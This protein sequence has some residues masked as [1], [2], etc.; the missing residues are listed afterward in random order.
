MWSKI[1]VWSYHVVF[2]VYV[3]YLHITI[4]IMV[5]EAYDKYDVV[6]EYPYLFYLSIFNR[7]NSVKL[8]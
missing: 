2:I 1:M 4:F 5:Y 3:S 8:P 7:N 6:N